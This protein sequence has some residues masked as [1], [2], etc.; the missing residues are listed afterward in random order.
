MSH[1]FSA[2]KEMALDIFAEAFAVKI[3]I[4]CLVYDNRGFGS[5]DC[6][7]NQPRH[8]VVPSVQI[9]DM[10][11]PLTYAQTKN[12]IDASKIGVWGSSLSA[13]HCLQ[14]AAVDRRVKACISQVRRAEQK[15]SADANN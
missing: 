7:S 14:V 9:A 12:E 8:E 10:Q 5:S 2:V 11:D 13:G 3:S 15:I 4:A 1:G 6:G